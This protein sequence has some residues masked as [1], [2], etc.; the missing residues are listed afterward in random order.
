MTHTHTHTGYMRHSSAMLLMPQHSL[1]SHHARWAYISGMMAAGVAE[2]KP[3][4]THWR[5]QR[6]TQW[7]C[8]LTGVKSEVVAACSLTCRTFW[9]TRHQKYKIIKKKCHQWH[10]SKSQFLH[11]WRKMSLNLEHPLGKLGC[12]RIFSGYQV[13]WHKLWLTSNVILSDSVMPKSQCYYK[14]TARFIVIVTFMDALKRTNG[15]W[16]RS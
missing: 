5:R 6:P 12:C 10:S 3:P 11:C 14:D 2:E 13:N 7:G 1:S 8:W 15:I 16:S 4:E 9:I